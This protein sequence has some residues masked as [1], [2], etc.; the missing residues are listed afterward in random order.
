MRTTWLI[1]HLFLLQ[2]VSS[3]D[4]CKWEDAIPV[5]Y[6]QYGTDVC[7]PVNNI[8]AE[9]Y[10]QDRPEDE[11]VSYC[12]IRTTFS[13]GPEQPYLRVPFCRG[14][15]TCKISEAVHQ[16]YSWKVKLNGNF[17][18]HALIIGVRVRND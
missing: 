3:L 8:E 15:L 12:S 6:H 4:V 18:I 9:G 5:L 13:Y 1:F 10:C 2:L 11:C 14:G 17:K 16:G 7:P